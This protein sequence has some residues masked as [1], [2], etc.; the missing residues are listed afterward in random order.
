MKIK[1]K[2]GQKVKVTIDKD[3]SISASFDGYRNYGSQLFVTNNTEKD[4]IE[5]DAE[6]VNTTMAEPGFDG[7]YTVRIDLFP[8]L[9]IFFDIHEI[10][11]KPRIKS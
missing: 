2:H 4:S 11:I 6:I 7:R 3:Y 9:S 1:Y 5:V 10:N 8:F